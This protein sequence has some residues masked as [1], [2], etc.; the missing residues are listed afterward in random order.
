MPTK[1]YNTFKDKIKEEEYIKLI[2]PLKDSIKK[3]REELLRSIEEEEDFSIL[4]ERQKRLVERLLTLYLE[5]I[6]IVYPQEDTVKKMCRASKRLNIEGI[7]DLVII[8]IYN[9]LKSVIQGYSLLTEPIALRLDVDLLAALR[10]Y[11][12]SSLETEKRISEL[13]E[14]KT[15]QTVGL[16]FLDKIH[17]AK[18]EHL[19][20]KNRVIR[21]IMDNNRDISIIKKANE[22][23]FAVLL[24]EVPILRSSKNYREI[25]K[26][27]KSFHKF[28]EFFLENGENLSSQK[29][30]LLIK[31]LE[32]LS[33]RMLYLLNEI[34]IELT[35]QYS[36]LDKLTESYNKNVFPIIFQREIK[37]AERYN[38]PVSILMIDIDDFK[39][40]NDTYGHITGDEVLKELSKIIRGNIRSSDYLFRFGGEEF[41]ILLP[42]TT[43]SDALKAAEKIRKNIEKASFTDKNL[44]ITISCGIAQVNNFQNPY[45]DLEEADKM[46]YVSKKSGKNR[47]T[48]YQVER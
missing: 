24:S 20:I 6:L 7:P 13:V 37:R 2:T 47:C 34:Q 15:T 4:S 35:S 10:H 38:F 21:S 9:K 26:I 5:N 31:E 28:I 11:T 14:F 8:N 17:R 46:L 30:Y 43:S 12:I 3:L 18:K 23:K 40:I 27:H 44:K 45:L 25:E 22:C 19:S 16:S 1:L 39:K 41:I 36:F 42:H 48:L 32:S 29:K 33:L